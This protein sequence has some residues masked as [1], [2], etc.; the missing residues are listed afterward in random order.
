MPIR[1]GNI[2]LKRRF[3]GVNEIHLVYRGA[4]LLYKSITQFVTD[5]TTR[6]TADGGA[7]ESTANAITLMQDLRDKD[8]FEDATFVMIPSGVRSTRVAVQKPESPYNLLQRSEEFD[9]N[10]YSKALGTLT[11]NTSTAPDG[12][13]TADTFIKTS[14]V[15]T[16]SQ[17]RT[18]SSPYKR[19]GVYT[20]SVYF[21]DIDA[22]QV[23]TR[24]DNDNNTCNSSFFFS[25]KTFSNSGVNFISSSYEEL[26]D[27]WFR[28]R[29]TGNVVSTAWN[30]S[31]CNLFPNAQN[32]SILVWGA[33][34]NEGSA[35][36]PYQKTIDTDF[37]LTF[38]RA[39]TATFVNQQGVIETSPR[40]LLQRSEEFDN[41]SWSKV[42]TTIVP[43]SAI[44]PNGQTTA[45]KLIPNTE[46]NQHDVRADLVA[47]GKATF[48]CYFKAA[49]Y[50]VVSLYFT[51][52]ADRASF[53]LNT[54]QVVAVVG[55]GAVA[56]IV[57]V[58]NGW[59][60]CS[61]YSNVGT[62]TGVRIYIDKYPLF[63]FFAGDN[64]GG[65]F[66]WG[67]QL[68]QSPTATS[69]L[70][71]TDRLNHPRIDHSSGTPA[72][73]LE[74]QRSNLLLNSTVLS[75]QNITTTA[76]AHTLSFYGTGT[77]T[78][79]G[80]FTGS[81]VGTGANNRVTLTFTPTAG[82]LTVTVTGSVN[83]AQCEVGAYATSWVSTA[84]AAVTRV[85][86]MGTNYYTTSL[87]SFLN[88][89]SG[90][91]FID[92]D[93][94]EVK[95]PRNVINFS[96]IFGFITLPDGRTAFRNF[97][98]GRYIS[99][100]NRGS[101]RLK[102]CIKYSNNVCTYFINGSIVGTDTLS[103]TPS[104][105]NLQSFHASFGQAAIMKIYSL[106]MWNTPLT[107]AQCI[108]LTQ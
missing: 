108:A 21:K 65:L 86:D 22:G 90:T 38:T 2:N 64:I 51:V 54:V 42:R 88:P 94:L 59:R 47:F 76:V 23:L 66:A 43:N 67:A 55:A 29:L 68:E 39:S 96:Y 57:D 30:V 9:N 17:I 48:S 12:T 49:E 101:G 85:V 44:S 98:D 69:Y 58:G 3:R 105:A 63:Q 93:L 41:A 26:V 18:S 89:T 97:L 53:D 14:G 99:L 107:D 60:R 31:V 16:V 106:Y 34:L 1:I 36:L 20:L 81:L 46:D 4:V 87:S 56:N 15:N 61:L 71:T 37:D 72:L 75:T 24:L 100:L 11:P 52:S 83:N 25:T 10:Y 5:F 80:T 103:S 79:S 102:L 40:N 78:L 13:M 35:A 33:M 62:A 91:A 50:S 77:I 104:F 82:T 7:V 74:P 6:V 28:I 32:T 8:V 19:V 45:D 70:P 73:L 27:G 92:I 95:E 84:G